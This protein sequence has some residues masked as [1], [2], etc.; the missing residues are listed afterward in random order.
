MYDYVIGGTHN[1]EVDR[2]AAEQFVKL[3][4]S[5]PLAA[6]QNRIFVKVAA[7][8]WRREGIDQVLDLGSGLPTR[9]HLDEYLPD[10]QILFTD[11]DEL[12]VGYGREILSGH[13]GHDYVELDVSRT[14]LLESAVKAAFGD[15]PRLGI[16]FV[17]LSYFFSDEEVSELARAL[18]SLSAR[19][20]VLAMTLLYS[21]NQDTAASLVA[22][23]A[24]V[25]KSS[26]YLR[27]PGELPDLLAPW[28]VV[29]SRQVQHYALASDSLPDKPQDGGLEMHGLFAIHR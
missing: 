12:T 9:G 25:I 20:S 8:R 11:R 2:V 4:P 17:G 26:L 19:D 10:A 22:E 27:A 29:S 7:E 16:G 3:V 28:E 13:P 18:H 1:F 21:P 15:D 5:V 14:D 6:Q 24:R 23:Y